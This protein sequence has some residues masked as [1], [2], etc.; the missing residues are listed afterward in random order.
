MLASILEGAKERVP[1]P[2]KIL[3]SFFSEDKSPYREI[4]LANNIQ[5]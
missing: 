1:P 3:I 4:F 2:K 5:H